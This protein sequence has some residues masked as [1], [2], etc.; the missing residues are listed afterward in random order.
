[1]P[2]CASCGAETGEIWKQFCYKCWKRQF[3]KKESVNQ[4]INRLISTGIVTRRET[5]RKKF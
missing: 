2:E 1:M 5:G 3:T 4:K